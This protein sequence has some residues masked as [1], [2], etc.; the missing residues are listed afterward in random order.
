MMGKGRR[1]TGS[2]CGC[3]LPK[4]AVV[5]LEPGFW[6]EPCTT[7]RSIGLEVF[8]DAKNPPSEWLEGFNQI[9]I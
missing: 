7:P 6:T 5:T 2:R 1:A 4:T 8:S 3:W 9:P